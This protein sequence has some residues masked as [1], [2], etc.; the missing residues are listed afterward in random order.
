MTIGLNPTNLRN[1]MNIYGRFVTNANISIY[2]LGEEVLQIK[3]PVGDSFNIDDYVK[4]NGTAV[5]GVYSDEQMVNTKSNPFVITSDQ[6]IYVQMATPQRFFDYEIIGGKAVILKYTGTDVDIKIPNAIVDS[7]KGVVPVTDLYPGIFADTISGGT[8]QIKSLVIPN[9]VK[10]I[11]TNLL[12]GCT[13]ITK[14]STPF[15][16]P[17]TSITMNNILGYFFGNDMSNPATANEQAPES[18][19]EV[20]VTGGSALGSVA[21]AECRY[22]ETIRLANSIKK[23]GSNA[24]TISENLFDRGACFYDCLALKNINIPYGVKRVESGTFSCCQALENITIPATVNYIGFEAFSHCWKLQAIEIPSGVTSI[25]TAAFC[26]CRELKEVIIPNSVT[27]L[28]PRM[29]ITI[30]G[31][32]LSSEGM[33]FDQCFALEKVK[34]S[35]NLTELKAA[36]FRR[37][38]IKE[39]EIPASVTEIG[40]EVFHNCDNLRRIVVPENVTSIGQGFYMGS[41]ISSIKGGVFDNSENLDVVIF[42]GDAATLYGTNNFDVSTKIF[43]QGEYLSNYQTK[44]TTNASAI[45]ENTCEQSNFTFSYSS[46]T[47]EAKITGYRGTGVN[48]V[49]PSEIIINEVSYKVTEIESFTTTTAVEFISVPEGVKMISGRGFSDLTSLTDI[50]LPFSL[51]RLEATS[52]FGGCTA[53]TTLKFYEKLENLRTADIYN[54]GITTLKF[55]STTPPVLTIDDGKPFPSTLRNIYVWSEST[56][57]TQVDAYKAAANWS[58]YASMITRGR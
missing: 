21:F 7:A 13:T 52:A 2:G 12:T 9:N 34:L 25:G 39:I 37:T 3:M 41:N 16:G 40:P 54:T 36:M 46:E 58:N 48:V 49:I 8:V 6:K 33:V 28:G 23:L 15:L 32:S 45:F 56:D 5:C 53:L 50:R 20:Y 29:T 22:I 44:W 19:T 1:D 26:E 42:E 30:G 31:Y 55:T 14:L 24:I 38:A 43:V 4:F 51:E 18:L 17:N 11:G 27:A 57:T 47:G 10:K 35:Q